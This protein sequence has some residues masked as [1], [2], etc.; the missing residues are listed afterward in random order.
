MRYKNIIDRDSILF[1][2]KKKGISIAVSYKTINKYSNLINSNNLI[3]YKYDKDEWF[4]L[5]DLDNIDGSINAIKNTKGKINNNIIIKLDIKTISKLPACNY[6]DEFGYEYIIPNGDGHELKK[7]DL[8]PECRHLLRV[9]PNNIHKE[10]VYDNEKR[11]YKLLVNFNTDVSNALITMNGIFEPYE[12]IKGSKTKIVFYSA[13]ENENGFQVLRDN[14]NEVYRT[15]T[16][17]FDTS[18][19]NIF[20]YIWSHLEITNRQN[21]CIQLT[22]TGWY[23]FEYE[24]EP[25]TLLFYN[26]VIYDYMVNPVNSKYIKILNL[27]RGNIS[28]FVIED[29]NAITLRD[30]KNKKIWQEKLIGFYNESDNIVYFESSVANSIIL[31]NGIGSSY[32]HTNSESAVKL[33]IPEYI[34]QD[35]MTGID[36]NSKIMA[37][38]FYSGYIPINNYVVPQGKI[39]E[40]CNITLKTYKDKLV[41]TTNELNKFKKIYNNIS[42]IVYKQTLIVNEDNVNTI[43]LDFKPDLDTNFKI[44]I[45]NKLIST[46]LWSYSFTDNKNILTLDKSIKLKKDDIINL[47]YKLN[48]SNGLLYDDFY[49]HLKANNTDN[50]IFTL[51]YIPELGSLRLFING[52]EYL[53]PNYW[54]YNE[55]NNT[56]NWG[57]TKENGGFDIRDDF[58]V[59]ALY[60]LMYSSNNII[61]LDY[62]IKQQS[63]KGDYLH[64]RS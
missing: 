46:K 28:N 45:N 48:G 50:H 59:V 49:E 61:D 13:T 52:I 56:I 10:L 63:Q 57:W 36:D 2:C 24:F 34:N 3:Y 35:I 62:F 5:N 26:K 29:L 51:S 23:E 9:Y 44:F 47:Y 19:Y 27:S 37:I 1:I 11:C 8:I 20:P 14:E 22:D 16:G 38:N 31:Y 4:L 12:F 54:T 6:I 18:Y 64:V 41:R 30:M 21:K 25:G 32:I 53:A 58:D 33:K 39:S 60:D 17:E 7:K 15:E 55:L 42:N 40:L 43:E